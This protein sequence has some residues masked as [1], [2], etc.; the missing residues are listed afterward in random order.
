MFHKK[1]GEMIYVGVKT[2]TN[3]G[4]YS[5]G[6]QGDRLLKTALEV[7]FAGGWKAPSPFSFQVVP[8]A[9]RSGDIPVPLAKPLVG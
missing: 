6:V 1:L 2:L 4:Y 5:F 3:K 9:Q 8:P 7:M